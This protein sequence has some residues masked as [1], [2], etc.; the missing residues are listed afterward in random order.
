MSMLLN[1]FL[2]FDFGP[3]PLKKSIMVHR[4]QAIK[5]KHMITS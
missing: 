5:F 1:I 3:D 4:N 2:D